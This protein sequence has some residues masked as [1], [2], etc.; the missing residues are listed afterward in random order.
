MFLMI[1]RPGG[2]GIKQ[3]NLGITYT[4]YILSEIGDCGWEKHDPEKS[5]VFF[6]CMG[7]MVSDN[8]KEGN[9]GDCTAAS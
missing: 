9:F 5:L 6:I 8:W 3:I 2:F 1:K 7:G 4:E